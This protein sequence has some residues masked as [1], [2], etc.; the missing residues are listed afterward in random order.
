MNATT[1]DWTNEATANAWAFL[2][3]PVAPTDDFDGDRFD[4]AI[5]DVFDTTTDGPRFRRRVIDRI[6]RFL[7]AEHGHRFAAVAWREI[8]TAYAD[9]ILDVLAVSA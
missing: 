5:S 2:T 9:F 1:V 8:A 6:E 4:E 3:D 7:R